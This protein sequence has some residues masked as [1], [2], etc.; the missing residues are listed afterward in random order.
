MP[1]PNELSFDRAIEIASRRA[2]EWFKVHAD[3][4]L[5]LFNFYVILMGAALG[6]FGAAFGQGLY[7]LAIAVSMLVL[8]VTLAFKRLDMRVARLVKDA[9]AALG[10]V[11]DLVARVTGIEEARLS[12]AAERKD[13]VKSYRQSFNLIFL[14]GALL[15]LST[16]VV[17]VWK[18]WPLLDL[19]Y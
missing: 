1:G 7:L 17:A 2:E 6:G 15:G 4:R 8:V 3:Q 19:P 10:R 14:F 9:E 12:Q 16:L 18:A 5:R 11:D 13:D